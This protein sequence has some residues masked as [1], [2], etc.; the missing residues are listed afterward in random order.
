MISAGRTRL[1]LQNI[2]LRFCAGIRLSVVKASPLKGVWGAY[3]RLSMTTSGLAVPVQ[4]QALGPVGATRLYSV[5]SGWGRD[6]R[7]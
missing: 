7:Y 2:A 6:I 3:S 1:S 4:R 5:G